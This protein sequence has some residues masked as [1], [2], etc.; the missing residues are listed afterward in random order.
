MHVMDTTVR[1]LDVSLYRELKARAAIEGRNIGDLVNAAIRAYLA[2]PAP[3]GR[4][5]S[6]RDLAPVSYGR[7]S[8]RSSEQVD[9]VVYGV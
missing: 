8:E 6:L 7:G 9:A 5:G 1:N 4:R 2:R 3:G